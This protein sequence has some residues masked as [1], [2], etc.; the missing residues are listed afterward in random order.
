MPFA[1]KIVS[2][3]AN[4]CRHP[5]ARIHVII[6][7]RQAGKT[8]AAEQLVK[9]LRWPAVFAA[10]D[11]PLPPGPEWIESQWQLARHLRRGLTERADGSWWGRLVENAVGAHL[12]ATLSDPSWGV[13]WWREGDAEVDFVVTRGSLVWAVEVKSGRSGRISGLR[14]FQRE[15]PKA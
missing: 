13:T 1:T 12:L 8:T 15:Y 2:D 7:P 4:A 5:A 10:A 3:L 9:R 6:G 11:A 14:A